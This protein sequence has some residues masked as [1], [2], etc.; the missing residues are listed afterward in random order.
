MKSKIGILPLALLMTLFVSGANAQLPD[1][2]RNSY[3][4]VGVGP[5][6]YINSRGGGLGG[7]AELT[8]GK[9]VLTSTGL[10]GQAAVQYA[11]VT[12]GQ[13]ELLFYGH[14]DIFLMC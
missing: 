2:F 3:V 10:R 4:G 7:G 8:Y 11:T 13:S 6:Y 14:F 9:W 5:N 1:F 12:S